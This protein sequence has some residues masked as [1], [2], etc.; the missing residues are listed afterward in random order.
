MR[1]RSTVGGALEMFS[2]PL[3]LPL[4]WSSC[5]EC[6][7]FPLTALVPI[8]FDKKRYFGPIHQFSVTKKLTKNRCVNT[9]THET[10]FTDL[11]VLKSEQSKSKLTFTITLYTSFYGVKFTSYRLQWLR[12]TQFPVR[13]LQQLWPYLQPFVRYSF[14]VK[15][16]RDLEICVW[17]RSRSLKMSPFDRP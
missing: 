4:L 2:L 9:N 11:N 3:P 17:G 14:S 12:K 15:E 8:K 6:K 13:V 7:I 10:N 5:V 16:W 1:R